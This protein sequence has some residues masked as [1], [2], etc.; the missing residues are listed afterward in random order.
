MNAID[1]CC[2]FLKSIDKIDL[3]AP[4]LRILFCVAAG[5]NEKNAIL[6]FMPRDSGS[7]IT[8]I[9]RRLHK[10]GYLA[11]MARRNHGY[12][13]TDAGK[14]RIAHILKFLPARSV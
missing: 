9:L 12:K 1:F 5:L 4:E 7:S 8:L 6:S 13:L 3:S 14:L 11:P 2:N 10:Q